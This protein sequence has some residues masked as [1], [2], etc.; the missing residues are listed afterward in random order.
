MLE[1]ERRSKRL[2]PNPHWVRSK[3][4]EHVM[5]GSVHTGCKQHQRNCPQFWVLLVS[6]V[7]WALNLSLKYCF[8]QS[9]QVH[10]ERV[11][12]GGDGGDERDQHQAAAGPAGQHAGRGLPRDAGGGRQPGP[13]LQRARQLT[14]WVLVTLTERTKPAGRTAGWC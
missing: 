11:P 14:R 13:T 2:Q 9:E 3:Q 10:A 7:D 5:N 12:P 1:D 6:R 8:S 4:I